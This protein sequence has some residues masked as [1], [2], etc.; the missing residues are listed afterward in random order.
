ML[1]LLMPNPIRWLNDWLGISAP[2]WRRRTTHDQ[3]YLDQILQAELTQNAP[4]STSGPAPADSC[5]TV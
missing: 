3:R 5:N 1:H 2:L 4:P